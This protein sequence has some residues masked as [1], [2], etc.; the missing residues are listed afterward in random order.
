M[1]PKDIE[2]IRTFLG[3][4]REDLKSDLN[5]TASRESDLRII[6]QRIRDLQKRHE[7]RLRQSEK[8]GRS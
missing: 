3:L 2:R 1:D 6:E 8:D 7:D 5:E 4:L